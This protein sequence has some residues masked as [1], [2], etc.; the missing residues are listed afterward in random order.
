MMG[1]NPLDFL[2]RGLVKDSCLRMAGFFPCA[3]TSARQQSENKLQGQLHVEWL[4]RTDTWRAIVV[5]DGVGALTKSAK[6]VAARRRKV[7][8]VEDVEHF[9]AELSFQAL[10]HRNVLEY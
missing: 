10:G 3:A 5:A 8:A 4:T 6:E 7:Q 1:R 2:F 9:H